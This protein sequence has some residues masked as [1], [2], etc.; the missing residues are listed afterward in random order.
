MAD[1]GIVGIT[2]N[3]LQ[4]GS[5]SSAYTNSLATL[6]G[7]SKTDIVA[8]GSNY[9]NSLAIV[10]I[11][12]QTSQLLTD[13]GNSPAIYSEID[14][15]ANFYIPLT[16]SVGIYSEID[17]YKVAFSPVGGT[18]NQHRNSM[19]DITKSL[20]MPKTLHK[21]VCYTTPYTIGTTSGIE[22]TLE[23][24]SINIPVN[25]MFRFR[26]AFGSGTRTISVSAKQPKNGTPRPTVVIKSNSSVGIPIDVSESAIP[27]NGWVTIGPITINPTTSGATWVEL[28]NNYEG[29]NEP[30]Y[31]DN[32][33]TT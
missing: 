28:H 10:S 3:L 7:V 24:P 19:P 9:S 18:F 4:N 30:C 15:Y 33:I 13:Y 1:F 6:G 23:P 16:A 8:T 11:L 22:G 21:L 32:I 25:G 26:W 2:S 20:F 27:D 29:I 5:V 17:P 31:F 12:N 14:P